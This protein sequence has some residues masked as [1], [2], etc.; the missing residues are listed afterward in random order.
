MIECSVRELKKYFGANKIFDN[1]SFELKTSERVGLIGQNGCGKTTLMKILMGMED[2]QGG[3]I[4]LRK[5]V[6]LGYLEQIHCVEEALTVRDVLRQAYEEAI[7]LQEK[8][9][10]LEEDMTLLTDEALK[11]AMESYGRCIEAYEALGGYELEINIDRVCQGLTIP[12]EMQIRPFKD[13]S[14]GEKTRVILGKL[15]LEAPDILL[16]DEPTNH[17]DIKSIEWLEEFL[18]SYKGTILIISHDRYFLDKVVTKILELWPQQMN[19][20]NGN[21]S[22]Y[23]IERER[24]F[25]EDFKRYQNQQKQIDRMKEQIHRYRVW[26]AMRDSEAM[27]KRAKEL[28]KRLEKIDVLDRPIL[29]NRKM[30]MEALLT[31]RSGKRVVTAENIVK[32]YGEKGL[33]DQSSFT[34]F[35]QDSIAL[36]G[37]NGSGKTT[38]L[39]MILGEELPDRGVIKLGSGVKIGYLPQQVV[40]EEEGKTLLEYFS[41]YHGIA[42]GEARAALAKMLFMREDV[43]KKI[44]S[45]SGGEKSRLKLCSL[46]YEK[47]NLLILDEP[48]NHLDI[49]SREVLE[50]TLMSFEGT[51]LFVSHDRYFIEKMAEKLLLIEDGKLQLYPFGYQEWVREREKS[52]AINIKISNGPLKNDK[53][54]S[55]PK[56]AVADSRL[57][58]NIIEK[59]IEE[60][61]NKYQALSKE[62]EDN[63]FDH[64]LLDGL[65]LERQ[66]L[67]QKISELYHQW[68]AVLKAEKKI[69]GTS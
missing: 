20:F 42:Q 43:N 31:D 15:L 49:D 64:I 45:L 30:K 69:E 11:Q 7:A 66:Q 68:D 50:N 39:K 32:G 36:M 25:L 3:S 26:G 48:T 29:E 16:L 23:V 59:Q 1:I 17:L 2:Y 47:A 34:I 28:E 41:D 19:S 57:G 46:T 9:K 10:V 14:G 55:K 62:M 56:Q 24:R 18:R 61:E 4:S 65:E 13:L 6:K 37:A 60:L 27:Y 5:G 54:K 35:Y 63:P 22:A 21:Y 67:D 51:L 38:L 44:K 53:A 40:F 33:I 8:I 12:D 58:S 52:I